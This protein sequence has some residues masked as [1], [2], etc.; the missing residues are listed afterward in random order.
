MIRE[1]ASDRKCV[2]YYVSVDRELGARRVGEVTTGKQARGR[3]GYVN[4]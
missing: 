3:S 4:I 2:L 1:P